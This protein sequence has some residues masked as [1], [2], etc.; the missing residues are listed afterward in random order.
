MA[1][2]KPSVKSKAPPKKKAVAEASF[3]NRRLKVMVAS[4]VYNFEPV[5]T[6]VCA[7]LNGYGYDVLN[8]HY[9]TITPIF[10]QSNAAACLKAV[11]ECDI[12]FCIIR[13]FY[14]SGITHKELT[15]AIKLNLPRRFMAHKHVTFTRQLLESLMYSKRRGRKVRTDFKIPKKTA[16][17][18]DIRVVD[19]YNEAIQDHLEG[20]QRK[21]HWAQEFNTDDEVFRHVEALFRNESKVRKELKEL[22]AVSHAKK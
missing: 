6:Q 8:S 4:T 13:P 22:K 18:D 19:M 2:K 16:V 21:D 3:D 15:K 17:M 10:G 5:L 7:I 1:K 20:D 12:F 14:G 11:E 9:G